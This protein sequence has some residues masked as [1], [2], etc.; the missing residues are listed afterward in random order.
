MF[1]AVECSLLYFCRVQ[2]HFK[3]LRYII[4]YSSRSVQEL[5][6]STVLDTTKGIEN[7]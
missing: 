1:V 5:I 3:D 4:L 2:F 6:L 7:K